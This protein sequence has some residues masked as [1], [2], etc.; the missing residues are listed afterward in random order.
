MATTVD[1]GYIKG[2]TGPQ[3]PKGDTGSQG[4]QGPQGPKGDTGNNGT[5]GVTPNVSAS[6][7]VDANIGTPSVTVTKGGT[8]T[9]PTFAFAFKNLKGSKGE[10]GVNATTTAVATTSANGLMSASDKSKLDD[11]SVVV[12]QCFVRKDSKTGNAVGVCNYN[13]YTGKIMNI[14]AFVPTSGTVFIN[15][16]EATKLSTTTRMLACKSIT[17]SITTTSEDA[18]MSIDYQTNTSTQ[19]TYNNTYGIVL[20][21][22]VNGPCIFT[23]IINNY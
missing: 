19:L 20:D 7:T 11:I 22:N 13:A 15:P 4:P 6:A 21:I 1:L 9:S 23:E 8:T 5:N 17:G 12:K 16:S 2:P 18:T 3:G 14:L 10:A